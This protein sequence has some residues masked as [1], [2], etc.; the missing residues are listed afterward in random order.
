MTN[1]LFLLRNF[2]E[3]QKAAFQS[4][5]AASLIFQA[6]TIRLFDAVHHAMAWLPDES[7]RHFDEWKKTNVK[8]LS[9]YKAAMENNFQLIEDCLKAWHTPHS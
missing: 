3:T 1:E 5:F 2:L 8:G 6:G 7:K 9:D 4:F